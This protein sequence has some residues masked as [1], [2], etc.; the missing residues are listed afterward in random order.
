MT[1]GIADIPE[2]F[3]G[4]MLNYA[5]NLL[6]CEEDKVAIITYG[7]HAECWVDG[8][9]MVATSDCIELYIATL[10]LP[11][12]PTSFHLS[13][14]P[15]PSFLSPSLPLS[16]L[17][18]S[19]LLGEGQDAGYVTY[20]E[21]RQQVATIAAALRDMGI[22]KGD[23]IVGTSVY[24]CGGGGGGRSLHIVSCSSLLV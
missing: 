24:V 17:P 2:W 16:S 22:T 9:Q 8:N 5:E 7:K 15:S 14:H 6:K 21:L 19:P 18:P 13:F 12:P 3:H 20:P 10:T 4:C 11:L 1:K 23:R